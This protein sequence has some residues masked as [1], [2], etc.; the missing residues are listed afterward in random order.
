MLSATVG[1]LLI[2]TN[3]STV[4]VSRSLS[5]FMDLPGHGIGRGNRLFVSIHQGYQ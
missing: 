5:H 4:K 1:L 2:D 3:G